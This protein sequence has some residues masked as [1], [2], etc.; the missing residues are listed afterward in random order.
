MIK[1]L[2][3]KLAMKKLNT[4]RRNIMHLMLKTCGHTSMVGYQCYVD[5]IW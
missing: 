1:R 4:K 3:A 5:W 2:M